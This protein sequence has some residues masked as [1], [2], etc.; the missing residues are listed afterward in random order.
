[1]PKYNHEFNRNNIVLTFDSDPPEYEVGEF[2]SLLIHG[3]V[4]R[5]YVVTKVPNLRTCHLRP[6]KWHDYPQYILSHFTTPEMAVLCGCTI[7]VLIC[8]NILVTH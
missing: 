7:I 5:R 8:I 2:V 1:M 6:F 3:E 4:P